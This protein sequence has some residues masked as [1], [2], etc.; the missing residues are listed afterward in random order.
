MKVCLLLASRDAGHELK[1]TQLNGVVNKCIS[2]TIVYREY[3][4]IIFPISNH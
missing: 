3:R 1:L 4:V 2:Y